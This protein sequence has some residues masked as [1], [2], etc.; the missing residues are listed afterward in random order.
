MANPPVDEFMYS[1]LESRTRANIS[2]EPTH[3]GWIYL[4]E[5]I[6]TTGEHN[7]ERGK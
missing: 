6:N 5:N 1:G 7:P 4:S 3:F 2:E